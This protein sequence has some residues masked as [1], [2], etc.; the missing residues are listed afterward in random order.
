MYNRISDKK[1]N[2]TR[3]M[4]VA[5]YGFLDAGT[6][7]VT[8]R[9]AKIDKDKLYLSIV[10]GF[11]ETLETS[12]N[13]YNSIN[14]S[15]LIRK[16][17]ASVAENI[18]DIKRIHNLSAEMFIGKQ[19]IITLSRTQGYKIIKNN[20]GVLAMVGGETVCISES[21]PELKKNMKKRGIRPS[22]IYIKSIRR[23]NEHSRQRTIPN[24]KEN[25]TPATESNSPKKMGNKGAKQI[26]TRKRFF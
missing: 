16:L 7:L 19:V 13:I 9:D 5:I 26:P 21:V 11:N 12:I 14:Y 23:V 24:P 4:D 2:N 8:I 10:N 1:V 25:K 6:H 18:D 3:D 15:L 20:E 17:L 22:D